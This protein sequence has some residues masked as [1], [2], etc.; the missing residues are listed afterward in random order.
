MIMDSFECGI[1][2][3]YDNSTPLITYIRKNE[4]DSEA[5]KRFDELAKN[6]RTKHHFTLT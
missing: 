1:R 6:I 5:F 3:I 4:V 2:E